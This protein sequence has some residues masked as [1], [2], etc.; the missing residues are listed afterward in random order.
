MDETRKKFRSLKNHY[1]TMEM[2]AEFFIDMKFPQ[3]MTV[4][5]RGSRDFDF[6][7]HKR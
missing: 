7:T 3:R 4:P 6:T 1:L 5:Y 2:N